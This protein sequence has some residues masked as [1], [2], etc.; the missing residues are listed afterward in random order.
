VTVFHHACRLGLEDIV[1]KRI[2]APYRS[3]RVTTLIKVK[4]KNAAPRA[5]EKGARTVECGKLNIRLHRT[6]R[7]TTQLVMSALG[8]NLTFG[9]VVLC[10][11]VLR[12][13]KEQM[14][15]NAATLKLGQ[16]LAI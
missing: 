1:S 2:D 10:T 15:P 14:T 12:S 7:D 5:A 8:Q 3:G 9:P 6:G 16:A 11:S 4:N 13:R